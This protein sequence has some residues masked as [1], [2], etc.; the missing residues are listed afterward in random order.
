M[1]AAARSREGGP[2]P[3][4]LRL[5]HAGVFLALAAVPLGAAL[6]EW[7]HLLDALS[8]P[9]HVGAPPRAVLLLGSVAAAV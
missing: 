9:F 6:P 3:W 7:R 2:S 5:V 8:R 4:V 1:T